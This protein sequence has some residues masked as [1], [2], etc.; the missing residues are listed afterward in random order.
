MF[1]HSGVGDDQSPDKYETAWMEWQP[2]LFDI[3]KLGEP[4][5]PDS[6]PPPQYSVAYTP[7]HNAA[8]KKVPDVYPFAPVCTDRRSFPIKLI[9]NRRMTDPAHDRD[10]RNLVFDISGTKVAA[11]NAFMVLLLRVNLFS[12]GVSLS[13][14]L[15]YFPGDCLAIYPRN[16]LRD[17][18]ELCDW[19]GLEPDSMTRIKCLDSGRASKVGGSFCALLC[20]DVVTCF[21]C[22]DFD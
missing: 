6:P 7:G 21:F 18:V 17:A 5:R 1:W 3:L 14:Q 12:C 11:R 2:E 4:E 16:S 10:V 22:R 15:R 8:W 20:L 19:L 13:A 9:E